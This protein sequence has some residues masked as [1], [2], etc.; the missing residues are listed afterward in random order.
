MDAIF[1]KIFERQSHVW[2]CYA[3]MVCHLL[4]VH[5]CVCFFHSHNI[6]FLL[7]WRHADYFLL[8][9]IWELSFFFFRVIMYCGIWET[10]TFKELCVDEK[11]SIFWQ[12]YRVKRDF[13]HKPLSLFLSM[14]LATLALS[15]FLSTVSS[16]AI[17][18]KK[19]PFEGV[20]LLW[21]FYKRA[22]WAFYTRKK[23]RIKN[24]SFL[25][26]KPLCPTLGF[27]A[28]PHK[29]KR[30]KEKRSRTNIEFLRPRLLLFNLS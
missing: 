10:V 8:C 12:V 3:E 24:I 9:L 2:N 19:V 17:M 4:W 14:T 29:N 28:Q 27:S 30:K 7:P 1:Y 6:F 26:L 15:S 22:L 21:A 20:L 5:N 25:S 18:K 13:G 16:K 23:K 11:K